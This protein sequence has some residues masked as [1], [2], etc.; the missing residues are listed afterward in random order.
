MPRRVQTT[1]NRPPAHVIACLGDSLTSNGGT[2][3]VPDHLMWPETLALR[4]R[5]IG[6]SVKARNFGISGQRSNHMINRADCCQQYEVPDIALVWTGTND[7][8]SPTWSGTGGSITGVSGKYMGVVLVWHVTSGTGIDVVSQPVAVAVTTTSTGS[9]SIAAESAV[10][11]NETSYDIYTTAATYS[12]ALAAIQAGASNY[13]HAATSA[14]VTGGAITATTVTAIGSGA[15]LSTV[16]GVTAFTTQQCIQ[17]FARSIKFLARGTWPYVQPSVGVAVANQTNLPAGNYI[18]SRIVVMNDTSTTGGQAATQGG[19]HTTI[20]GTNA[21]ITVWE[22]R[23]AYT[24]ETGWGRVAIGSTPVF[25]ATTKVIIPGQHYLNWSANGDTLATPYQP[26]DDVSGIRSQQK[27]AVAAEAAIDGGQT[28][29]ADVYA[30]LKAR[31]GTAPDTQGSFSWHVADQNV[32]RNAYGED[33]V[34]IAILGNASTAGTV[35]GVTNLLA[36]LES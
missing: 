12:S 28:T 36:Q 18:G 4:L 29:Y 20:T 33:L 27:A 15:A 5:N 31:I 24:G 7:C 11:L 17:A 32:H 19:Q 22:W 8:P 9:F 10:P 30:F 16:Q 23:Y 13:L 21:G 34:A 35:L 6:A 25:N 14:T 3:C 2:Y 1:F 26:Y